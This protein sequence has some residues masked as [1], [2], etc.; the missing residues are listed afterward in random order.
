MSDIIIRKIL[1]KKE[2][3]IS[4]KIREIVFC[5][6]QKVAREIEFDG[7]DDLCDHYLVYKG[8]IPIA[9]ARFREKLPEIYKIERVAVLKEERL[10]GI[11]KL[12]MKKIINNIQAKIKTK[13]VFLHSQTYVKNFYK[14]LGFSEIGDEFC[15]DGIPHIKMVFKNVNS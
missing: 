8:N 9:T 3:L 7:L 10:K 6:E 1:N 5:E 15:E 11:G 14:G 12:L 2:L 4:Q 13:C